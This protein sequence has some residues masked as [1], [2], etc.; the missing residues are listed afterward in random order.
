MPT[1]NQLRPY[2]ITTRPLLLNFEPIP[3]HLFEQRQTLTLNQ[4][5]FPDES[6]VHQD[7]PPRTK[8]DNTGSNSCHRIPPFPLQKQRKCLT[9]K[10]KFKLCRFSHSYLSAFLMKECPAKRIVIS[11]ASGPATAPKKKISLDYR[12]SKLCDPPTSVRTYRRKQF[13]FQRP[14]RI[15]RCLPH[16][17]RAASGAA[18][19]RNE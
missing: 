8:L 4:V 12:F 11:A 6:P 1:R 7:R 18:P 2:N 13:D 16:P 19:M 10:P 3:L 17:L 5:I 15:R 14:K 9:S